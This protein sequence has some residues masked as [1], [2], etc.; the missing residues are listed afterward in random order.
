MINISIAWANIEDDDRILNFASKFIARGV[1]LAKCR[2]LAHRY[3]Y[4]NYAAVD[5]K[6]FGSYGPT[7]YARLSAIH[8]KYD[9]TG[10]FTRLQP[11]YFKTNEL[12]E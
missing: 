5:Q 3:I 8:R 1:A 7:N 11:G 6:V 4:Q 12:E 9:P 10:V 2:K